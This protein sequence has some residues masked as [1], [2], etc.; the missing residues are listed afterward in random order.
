MQLQLHYTNY[1]TPQLQL[2][3]ATATATAALHHT[4]SSSCE[5]ID[6]VTTATIVTTPETQLQ[7]PCSPSVDSLCQPW[8]TTT[9]LS[10]WSK[11]W[12]FRHRLVRYYWYEQWFMDDLWLLEHKPLAK[13]SVLGMTSAYCPG[14]WSFSTIISWNHFGLRWT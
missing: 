13:L 10:Y 3:Y 4:T 7:P 9:K 2:H 14:L 6:Q 12:N 11:C 5:V 1:T 8:F